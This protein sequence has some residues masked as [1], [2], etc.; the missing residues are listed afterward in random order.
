MRRIGPIGSEMQIENR[1]RRAL[2]HREA[3]TAAIEGGDDSP[4]TRRS[5]ASYDVQIIASGND[6]LIQVKGE[7]S[8][9][10]DWRSRHVTVVAP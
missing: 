10:V 6:A 1:I 8:H 2:A 4:F 5:E 3:G 9:T 7:T